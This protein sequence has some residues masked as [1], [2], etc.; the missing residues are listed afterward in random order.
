M[1]SAPASDADREQ[2]ACVEHGSGR[3]EPGATAV[4]QSQVLPR[5]RTRR[6]HRRRRRSATSSSWSRASSAQTRRRRRARRR[7][8]WRVATE[9]AS[10]SHGRGDAPRPRHRERST[11]PPGRGGSGTEC[12][13]ARPRPAGATHVV[14]DRAAWSPAA[15]GTRRRGTTERR[16]PLADTTELDPQGRPHARRDAASTCGSDGARARAARS[17]DRRRTTRPSASDAERCSAASASETRYGRGVP[18]V[19][20]RVRPPGSRPRRTACERVDD[21]HGTPCDR[22]RP[23]CEHRDRA[24][25][26]DTHARPR[27]VEASTG[28]TRDDEVDTPMSSAQVAR[29]PSPRVIAV[30]GLDDREPVDHVDHVVA[31]SP[32]VPSTSPALVTTSTRVGAAATSRAVDRRGRLDRDLER[33]GVV[34]RRG[35]RRARPRRGIA[36]ALRPGGS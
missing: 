32:P 14:D 30:V 28:P 34:G 3:A 24:R 21:E 27:R 1:A 11:T 31:R 13:H 23:G 18:S 33:L 26:A 20:V 5:G 8:A 6:P 10:Q 22:R 9:G 17:S 7:R 12:E 35:A 4:E 15:R 29:T 19:A 36:S 2:P 16:V 25:R